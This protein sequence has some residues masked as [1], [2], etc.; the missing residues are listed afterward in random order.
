MN[1]SDPLAQSF[2]VDRKGGVF[3]SSI[4][5]FFKTKDKSMPVSV[6]IRNM[7]NGYPGQIV[8]PFSTKTLE[9]ADINISEDG[10]TST[11][12]TFES[13]VFLD[14]GNEYCFVVYSN[15]NEYEC[16][17]SRMGEPDLVTGETISGQP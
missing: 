14:T 10:S 9:P 1:W 4:D 6:H 17:I 3:L 2:L 13:P 16:F 7:V 15:S 11:T 12:F 5:L 8:V